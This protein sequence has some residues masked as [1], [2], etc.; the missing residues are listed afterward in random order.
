MVAPLIGS[1]IIGAGASLLGGIFGRNSEKSAIAR[2]NAY[3]DPAQIRARAEAAGFNPLLFVGPGV[4]QQTAVGGS[5]YMGQAIADAG[6]MAAD[7]LSEFSAQQRLAK[8]MDA[9]RRLSQ[10]LTQATIRPKVGGIY[11]RSE[12]FPSRTVALGGRRAASAGNNRS[13][14]HSPA[15]SAVPSGPDRYDIKGQLAGLWIDGAWVPRPA[16][17]SSG[18]DIENELG[19]S[20]AAEAA[21]A[22]LA[23]AYV[24]EAAKVGKRHIAL[25]GLNANSTGRGLPAHSSGAYDPRPYAMNNMRGRG[26]SA[27]GRTTRFPGFVQYDEKTGRPFAGQYVGGPA[28]LSTDAGW[29]PF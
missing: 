25:L 24:A 4:G 18:N 29:W 22:P 28:K 23:A 15:S 21:V 6:L 17:Y 2:Q 10:Q 14:V 13:G 20:L 3:N 19:D 27:F 1:A 12:M 8:A 7:K 9:N 26:R 5:N 11:A 16:G